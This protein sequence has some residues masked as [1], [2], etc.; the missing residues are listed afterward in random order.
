VTKQLI[1]DIIA[2]SKEYPSPVRLEDGTKAGA[3][4][5]CLGYFGV[6]LQIAL[7]ELQHCKS[8][9]DSL[10]DIVKLGGDTDTTG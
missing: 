5:K 7:Y 4:G 9:K 2:D 8:F 3:D 6:A 10:I 1:L